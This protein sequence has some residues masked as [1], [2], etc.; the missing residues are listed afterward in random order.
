MSSTSLTA[1]RKRK[2]S[3]SISSSSQY[4]RKRQ[5]TS[6]TQ[7]NNPFT[8]HSRK[9]KRSSNSKSSSRENYD[10]VTGRY[11][12][13]HKPT[14]SPYDSGSISS[15]ESLDSFLPPP[16]RSSTLADYI[17]FSRV[18]LWNRYG[19]KFY[20][21]ASDLFI[22]YIVDKYNDRIEVIAEGISLRFDIS[23][24][25]E[26]VV[27]QSDILD[28]KLNIAL[29]FSDAPIILIPLGLYDKGWGHANIIIINKH[30]KTIE[31]LDPHGSYSH[32]NTKG[33]FY[34]YSVGD[35]TKNILF[36]ESPILKDQYT[37]LSYEQTCPRFGFQFIETWNKPSL[38]QRIGTSLPFF[39]KYFKDLDGY[40]IFW[41][42]FMAELR[43][44][45]YDKSPQYIQEKD[46]K[47]YKE[48]PKTFYDFIRNYMN[49]LT[50]KLETNNQWYEYP[51]LRSALNL[52]KYGIDRNS[53]YPLPSMSRSN[54]S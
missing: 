26:I 16:Q 49:F 32:M 20:D 15:V 47:K 48:D 27:Q 29:S 35:V 38:V 37:F 31:L 4:S 39:S 17:P 53:L 41:T 54:I 5:L 8:S 33:M 18:P 30:F 51:H 13:K 23:D 34:K 21:I 9:R 7:L 40:C 22:D 43:I 42:M 19:K 28:Q 12:K 2:K 11:R 45:Y 36:S 1:T 52:S 44:N 25:V 50:S 10:L 14:N 3:S 46:I 6:P 24:S